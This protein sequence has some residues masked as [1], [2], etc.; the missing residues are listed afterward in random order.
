VIKALGSF[1]DIK[2]V[3]RD[4]KSTFDSILVNIN[5]FHAQMK[6]IKHAISNDINNNGTLFF[7]IY[8]YD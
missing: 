6:R 7:F 4:H 3:G 5:I 8:P 2:R 1:I